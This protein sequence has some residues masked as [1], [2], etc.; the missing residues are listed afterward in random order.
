[1]VSI[2]KILV[3]AIGGLIATT[4]GGSDYLLM[5]L[6][7]LT[8]SDLLLGGLKGV[9]NKNF[10]SSIFFWGLI[11]KA[12]IFMIVAMMVKADFVIGKEGFLRNTFIIWFSICES[13]S[14]IENSA[15]LGLP[16][17][18]GLLGILVQVRKGFSINLSKIVKQIIDNYG[19]TNNEKDGE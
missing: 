18:D 3:A 10:S 16:W 19:M 1:M 11:N 15:S 12:V 5:L 17:P 4:L 9:K 13:A 2:I 8:G 7:Y 6:M 14:I